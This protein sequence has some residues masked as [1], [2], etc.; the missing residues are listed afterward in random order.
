VQFKIDN[1]GNVVDIR[2]KAPHPD[3]EIEA[4]RIV[5]SLPQ[6]IP[7]EHKGKKVAVSYSLPILFIIDE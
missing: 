3:L 6:M 2:S 7:G 4:T 1:T 5:N